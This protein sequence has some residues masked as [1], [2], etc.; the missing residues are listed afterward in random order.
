MRGVQLYDRY[1]C[2]HSHTTLILYIFIYV[3]TYRYEHSNRFTP[4]RK[5]DKFYS[6]MEIKFFLN[7]RNV[8]K[9]RDFRIFILLNKFYTF[10]S[11]DICT[12]LSIPLLHNI[13][14]YP[15]N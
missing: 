13:S 6:N 5:E 10:L 1:V 9:T 7:S 15:A 3:C 11:V 12:T 2:T 4:E 8:V 14:Q